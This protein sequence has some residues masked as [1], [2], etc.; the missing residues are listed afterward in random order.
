MGQ[1][2]MKQVTQTQRHGRVHVEEVPAPAPRSGGVLVRTAYSLISAGTER[3]K[4][5]LARKSLLGKARARPEQARQVLQTLQQQGPLATYQK[6]MNRLEQL[7]PL[8]YSCSGIVLSV[9]ADVGEFQIGDR[10]ACAGAG[11]A[12][13]AEVNFVPQNL[14]VMVPKGVTLDAAAFS[15]VGAIALQGVRQAEAR[16]GETVIVI[17]LGLVGLLTLQLLRAAGCTVI[18]MDPNADRRALAEEFGAAATTNDE[19]LAMRVTAELTGGH[20][21]DAVIITA[22]TRSNGPVGLAGA[23]C[24]EKGRVV[25]VGDVRMDLPRPP[26]YSRELEVRLSRSYGPGRYDPQYEE[27][28]IDYPYGY[29]RWTEKRNM[30]AFLGLVAQG[31]V[32]INPLVSHRFKLGEAEKAYQLIEGESGEPY[33]GVLM[34]YPEP[35]EQHP[36][37]LVWVKAGDGACGAV[38]SPE[39]ADSA[40]TLGFIG[41]GNFAQD[42]LIP[43]LKSV[44]GVRLRGVSTSSG[45][46][47]RGVAD[48]F[49]FEYSASDS[50]ELMHD[51]EIHAI[52]V[53]T[54]HQSHAPLVSAALQARKHVFVEKPLALDDEQLRQVIAAHE[55]AQERGPRPI[56]MVGFN[57]RFA[58]FSQ[59][60]KQFFSGNSQPLMVHYRVN[61]GYIPRDHWTQDPNQG[62]GRVLGEVCHF[63]DWIQFVVGAS[64]TQVVAQ[65]LP[66]CGVY[67]DDNLS[68]TIM[69][70]DGS[71][72]NIVY[73]AN[74]ESRM[75][76]ERA[77]VMGDGRMGVIEDFRKLSLGGNGRIRT[78]KQWI[79]QDKGHAAEVRAFVQAIRSGGPSPIPFG[80]L[81]ATAQVTFAILQSLREKRPV[82]LHPLQEP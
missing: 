56:L 27:K 51:P 48:R 41:A 45:L 57:R 47:A 12:N 39:T 52:V 66:N 44:S 46:S 19:A 60:L 79:S 77:E 25:V 18:G 74:G 10:V 59:K 40:V 9:G 29:V 53:A 43:A 4:V 68:V 13:H 20:G 42:T 49:G 28:G 16:L 61:A 30:E 65:S 5:E 3:A 73:I 50:A 11:Y 24:R 82:E 70:A 76:K 14:C 26:Y 78:S 8:G 64:P 38:P 1:T 7:Q 23:L 33:L 69:Y 6:V 21:A 17:G 22:A 15:T 72:G 34:E 37:R 31:L 62:G 63:V 2:P 75:G 71:L 35:A 36:L 55:L 32:N 81:V 58:P 54:R 67:S 80:E